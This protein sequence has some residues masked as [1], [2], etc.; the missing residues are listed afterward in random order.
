MATFMKHGLL[1][2]LA[3]FVTAVACTGC[4]SAPKTR[5]GQLALQ[6]AVK[7]AIAQSQ[8]TDSSLTTFY[9]DSYGYVVFPEVG[10]GAFI[11]GGS[12]G[13][14]IVFQDDNMTGYA[15]MTQGSIG[16][17]VGGAQFSEMI[18]FKDKASYEKFIGGQWAPNANATAT[19]ISAGASATA[20]YDHG[21]AVFTLDPKGLMASAAIGAQRFE[22]TPSGPND[23]PLR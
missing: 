20:D 1:G 5:G 7:S 4:D 3:A 10:T 19:A 22:F 11:V 9:R 21:V 23:P 18:F 12:Y 17:Q 8:E 15:N 2:S 6:S 14:G 16:L 13:E